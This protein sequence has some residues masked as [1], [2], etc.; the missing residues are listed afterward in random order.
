[1]HTKEC[2]VAVIWD[3]L[4]LHVAAWKE[5]LVPF[6]FLEIK[7]QKSESVSCSVLSDSLQPHGLGLKPA[8]L[9]CPWDSSGMNTGVGSIPFSRGSSWPMDCT[10]ISHIA[11]RFFFTI[12]ATREAQNKA[13]EYFKT[14]LKTDKKN[15]ISNCRLSISYEP[16]T[17]D[18]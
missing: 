10:Q 4:N 18:T 2:Y 17:L 15:E 1:M 13:I 6:L 12:W 16:V 7:Q 3:K 9:L 14:N 5:L 8:R 11:G